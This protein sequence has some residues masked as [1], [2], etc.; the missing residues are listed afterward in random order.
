MKQYKAYLFD[1]DGTLYD[2]AEMIYQCFAYSCKKFGNVNVTRDAVFGNIG[3]PLR[4]QLEHFL[5]P[6]SDEKA[7]EV[8]QTHMAYQL[9]IY[10]DYLTLFPGVAETLQQ[11]KKNGKKLS[12]VTSRKIQTLSLYLETTG[13]K[14]LFDTLITPE[15]TREH[16]PE[17]E[18][19]FA[20][21]K[22]LG[23]APSEALFVGDSV[24]DIA[25]GAE[26]GTDTAFVGWSHIP[27]SSV[28]I[29][30]T[31]IINKMSELL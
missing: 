15:S 13:I 30:P 22:A 26:A 17:P 10:K 25:C 8:M 9:T 29:Q 4:P 7:A 5:G 19:A 24:Y 12:V 28:P 2:T 1:G 14:V 3:I 20:A 16:K 23:C 21:L 27:V 18:P 31:Y 11:L 6:L